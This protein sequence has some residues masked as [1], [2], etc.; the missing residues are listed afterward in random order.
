MTTTTTHS[1]TISIPAVASAKGP[2]ITGLVGAAGFALTYL[3]SGPISATFASA[4]APQPNA[5]G[6]VTR[7]WAIENATAGAIQAAIMVA[8]VVFLAVFVRAVAMIT[9]RVGGPAR[10]AAIGAGV[11]AV[12]AMVVSSTLSWVLSAAAAQMTPD[13]VGLLR[14][15]GFIAGGTAHVAF[16]GL[17]ALA[18]SRI[19][20][21]S[22]PVRITAIVLAVIAVGSLVSLGVYYA[23][24]LILAGRLLGMAWCVF[25][26]ISLARRARRFQTT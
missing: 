25:A 5:S 22:K 13:T 3:V 26:A 15:A 10:R 24:I 23:S 16:L 4:P 21:M 17:F 19:P 12:A 9:R 6:E 11:A 18:A 7:A 8:S 14:T 1:G 20:G 2:V